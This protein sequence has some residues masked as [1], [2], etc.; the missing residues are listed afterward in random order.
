MNDTTAS[1]ESI[2]RTEL[3]AAREVEAAHDT[4]DETLTSAREEARRIRDEGERRGR[5]RAATMLEEAKAAA[6]REAEEIRAAATGAA[7]A[8]GESADEHFDELVDAFVRVILSPPAE[9]ES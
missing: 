7:D 5:E 9:T 1:V 4:A 3:A 8:I 6:E 2:R